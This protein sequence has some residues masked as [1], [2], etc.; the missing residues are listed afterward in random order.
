MKILSFINDNSNKK[1]FKS[2][3]F[4]KFNKEDEFYLFIHQ[5]YT[6]KK[7][8]AKQSLWQIKKT[9]ISKMSLAFFM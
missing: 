5:D 8:Y 9:D 7:L 3:S 1:S 4:R 2:D 6:R